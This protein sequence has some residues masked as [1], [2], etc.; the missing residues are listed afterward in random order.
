MVK[1]DLLSINSPLVQFA[2][3]SGVD[4]TVSV[5]SDGRSFT[6]TS[7]VATV[8]DLTLFTQGDEYYLAVALKNAG[9]L[10]HL[11]EYDKTYTTN[12]GTSLSLSIGE[13]LFDVSGIASGEYEI[14]VYASTKDG[15]RSSTAAS[16]GR[17]VIP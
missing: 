17:I 12:G 8:N 15:I 2:E 14:V 16:V 7:A 9:G 5:A 6:I 11:G 3:L 10:V 13:N 1:A 4:A